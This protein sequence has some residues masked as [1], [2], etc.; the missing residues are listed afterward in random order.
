MNSFIINMMNK[1]GYIGIILLIAVENIFPPIPSEVILTLG[2]FMT[3]QSGVNMSLFGVIMSATVGSLLG[4]II[5][6][7]VGYIMNIDRVI[8]L[9]D[10]RVGKIL[11]LNIDNIKRSY[12][13]FNDRGYLTVL[14]SRFVPILRSLI[15]IPAG[16]NKMKFSLFILYTLIGSLIWN[17]VLCSLGRLVGNNYMLVANIFS[18]YSKLI[19]FLLIGWLIYKVI[20]IIV[21]KR[22]K[23]C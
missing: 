19:L 22:R 15:S 8:K 7:Y 23:V 12:D 9:C 16:M 21:N 5:L 2:G 20:K 14:Y 11:C 18:K 13:N 17:I 10:S 4:A 6:Y 3:G 1:Y